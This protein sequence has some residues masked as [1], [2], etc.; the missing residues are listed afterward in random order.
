MY[1]KFVVRLSDDERH[2]LK[3]LISSGTTSARI[4]RRARILIKSD[5][6]QQGGAW[7]DEAISRALD[8]SV[9]TIQ[10]V[11]EQYS[12][13]GIDAVLGNRKPRL[14]DYRRKLDTEA[15]ALLVVLFYIDPP[16]GRS[17]WTTKLLADRLVEFGYVD[18]ISSETIRKTLRTKGLHL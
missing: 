9:P 3:K 10:R 18:R 16:G 8:V 12:R 6:G 14:R 11:R 13:F 5:L 2:V 17:Q 15:E 4:Q 7:T 1:K